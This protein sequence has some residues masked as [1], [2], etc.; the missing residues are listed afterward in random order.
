MAVAAPAAWAA[1]GLQREGAPP[2]SPER[3]VVWFVPLAL[4]ALAGAQPRVDRALRQA[5]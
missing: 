1:S 2:P 3:Y 5:S 4:V